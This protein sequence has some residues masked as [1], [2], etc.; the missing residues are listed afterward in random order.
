MKKALENL[1]EFLDMLAEEYSDKF[2]LECNSNL[3]AFYSGRFGAYSNCV[4]F[5]KEVL[6]DAKESW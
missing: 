3:S 4:N 6:E 5:L 2:R 1:V